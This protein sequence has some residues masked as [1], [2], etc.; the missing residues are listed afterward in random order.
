MI[1]MSFRSYLMFALAVND[2]L[3]FL[4]VTRLF[5]LTWNFVDIHPP[6]SYEGIDCMIVFI[7]ASAA[8]VDRFRFHRMTRWESLKPFD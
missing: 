3:V 1:F 6:V 4:R 7:E 8:L 2:D 5:D